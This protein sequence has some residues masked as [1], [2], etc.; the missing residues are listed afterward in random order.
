M[1]PAKAVPVFMYHHVS[2]SPGLVTISP[3]C[4]RSQIAALAE[5]GWRT[6]GLAELADFLGGAELPERTCVLTFDDGYLDNFAHAHPILAEFDMRAVLFIVTGWLGDGPVRW[7]QKADFTHH[8]CKRAIADGQGDTVMLRWSEIAAMASAG[9]F[10]F[11]SHTHAHRRWDREIDDANRRRETILS[12]L[13]ASRSSL[14]DRLGAA[15]DHLCWPQGYFDN[16]YAECAVEA[17]FRYLYTTEK[18]IVS[19]GSDPLSLGRI[20]TKERSG[21]WLMRRARWF[22]HPWLGNAYTWLQAR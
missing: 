18:K 11:H 13:T 14:F 1:K 8:D 10:E 22:S 9:T 5:A 4:F 12:D 20:V 15:T 16:L 19:T 2:P 21:S 3:S 7:G 6:A 17:G